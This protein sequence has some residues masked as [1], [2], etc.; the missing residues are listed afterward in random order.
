M[1]VMPQQRK[2]SPKAVAS[3]TV[4]LHQGQGLIAVAQAQVTLSDDGAFH[5]NQRALAQAQ[6]AALVQVIERA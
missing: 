3:I 1:R 5:H 2:V 4:T 6:G